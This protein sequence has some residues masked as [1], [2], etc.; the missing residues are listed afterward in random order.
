MPLWS[1]CGSMMLHMTPFQSERVQ[2]SDII[3]SARRCQ[4]ADAWEAFLQVAIL[5]VTGSCRLN[6][7]RM[8]VADIRVRAAT[9]CYESLTPFQSERAQ[10]SDMA[11][12]ARRCQ[13]ADAWEAF[14]Q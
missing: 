5:S 1:S 13:T 11:C 2:I 4:T 10:I 12:S 14:L 3:R 9:L 6:P 7:S 8:G